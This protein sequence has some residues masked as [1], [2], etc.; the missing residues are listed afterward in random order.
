MTRFRLTI[1]V[2]VA[3]AMMS[4]GAAACT[5]EQQSDWTKGITT[6][7][8]VLIFAPL[9]AL[10]LS[11]IAGTHA[12]AGSCDGPCPTPTTVPVAAP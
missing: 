2:V 12:P 4:L 3:V 1:A 7:L 10:F 5:P 6:G 11:L 9:G 8:E